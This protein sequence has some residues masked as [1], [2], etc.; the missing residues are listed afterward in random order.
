MMLLS[1]IDGPLVLQLTIS[2]LALGVAYG[3]VG[4]GLSLVFGVLRLINFAHG[5]FYMLGAMLVYTLSNLAGVPYIVS[6]VLATAVVL[7]IGW[8]LASLYIERLVRT[9]ETAMLIGTLGLSYVILNSARLIWGNDPQELNIP[10][11]TDALT[12]PGG[13]GVPLQYLFTAGVAIVATVALVWLVYRT[14]QGT[15]MRAVAENRYAAELCG[16]KVSHVYRMT[17]ALGGA[18]AALAGTTAGAVTAVDFNIGQLVV[19]KAF[20]V[21]IIAGLGSISGAIYAGLLLGL[22]ETLGGGLISP[23]YQDAFGY[24]LMMVVLIALPNGLMNRRLATA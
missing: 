1:T 5:E 18:V 24:F 6:L 10:W 23:A 19:L 7:V 14:K 15:L 21:V 2:G 9:N 12:L 20:V 22:V 11:A 4:L 13:S 17:F 8:L 3:L 16:I